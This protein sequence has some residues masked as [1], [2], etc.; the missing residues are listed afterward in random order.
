MLSRPDTEGLLC[1]R[2]Q[3]QLY[4]S[5]E[6][7]VY[8]SDPRPT[9]S[10][11]THRHGHGALIDR[12][13]RGSFDWGCISVAVSSCGASTPAAGKQPQPITFLEM[14]RTDSDGQ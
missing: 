7:N 5:V 4:F 1:F 8:A 3:I 10:H 11:L 6:Y 13:H 9:A 14:V 2:D 12:F